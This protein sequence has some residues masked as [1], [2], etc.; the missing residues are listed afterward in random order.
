MEEGYK[1]PPDFAEET[2]DPLVEVSLTDSTELWLIQWPYNQLQ[3]DDFQGKELKLKLHHNGKLGTFE[4]ASGKSYD[5]VS[6]AVQEPEAT[7]FIPSA[8]KSKTVG[9]ISRRVSLIHYPEPAD[10]LEPMS[11]SHGSKSIR[12]SGGSARTRSIS[13]GNVTPTSNRER[14]SGLV[15]GTSYESGGLSSHSKKR[16]VDGPSRGQ[17]RS[18]RST[19]DS[20]VSTLSV[21]ASGLSSEAKLKSKIKVEE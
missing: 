21:G 16:R 5:L 15:S 2:K 4:S 13:H 11:S 6:F 3:P 9:K 14:D 18:D 1:P 7:V 10:F 12:R 20:G 8:S 19:R 17:A